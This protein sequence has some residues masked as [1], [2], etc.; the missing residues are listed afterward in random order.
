MKERIKEMFETLKQGR[1]EAC[2]S[3][4][5]IRLNEM[6]MKQLSRYG[7][8][9]F[10]RT[11]AKNYFTW[12]LI[13]PWHPQVI[14]LV[15]HVKLSVTIKNF[16][17]TIFLL[18]HKH[19]SLIESLVNSFLSLMVW[20]Y[21]EIDD[22]ESYLKKLEEPKIGN[23]VNVRIKNKLISQD[24]ANSVIEFRT[25]MRNIP[26]IKTICELG[27]GYGR[28]AFVFLKMLPGIK[29]IMVDIPP[30]LYISE[31]YLSEVFPEK[32]IFK[33]RKFNCFN[34]IKEDFEKA[35]ILFFVSSQIELI[36]SNIIDLLINISSL[37]EMMPSQ[38][39]YYFKQFER[40]AKINS[41]LYLKEWKD[42]ELP[43]SGGVHI[44]MSDYPVENWTK[45]LWETADI[46]PQL[47]HAIVK[48]NK[49]D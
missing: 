9:N 29:Y 30:A 38:I 35:D 27:G 34:E 23:P 19:I 10:K 1:N 7:Y 45:I 44:R 11:V 28:S 16:F 48:L 3:N 49:N 6:N 46:H 31:R 14:F 8:G 37:H 32:K 24:L 26:N 22:K 21:A 5:W 18:K 25:I 4:F 40:L 2:P 12:S 33:F 36:P 41:Y 47:F 15:T 20:Q 17:K 42:T 43:F 13:S 39:K